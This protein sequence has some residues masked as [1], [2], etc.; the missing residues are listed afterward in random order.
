MNYTIRFT[1]EA[2]E[3]FDALSAQLNKRW[4]NRYVLEFEDRVSKAIETISQTP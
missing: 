3:T 1:P 4:G 2:E